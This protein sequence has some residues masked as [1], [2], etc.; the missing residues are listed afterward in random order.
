VSA[1]L[2]PFQ[3]WPPILSLALVSLVTGVG[4]LL[5]FKYTS[6]QRA[7]S[8]TKRRIRAGLLEL[9]L[10]QDSPRLMRR[11]VGE[12][13]LQQ[14]RYLRFA[15]VPGLWAIV[16]L[17]ILLSHLHAYYGYD[18]LQPSTQTMLTVRLA[19]DAASTG[20]PPLSIE[21]PAGLRVETP[22]V[23]TP[24]L[25][26]GAWRIAAER[27]GEYDLRVTASGTDVTKR[28]VVS[29]AVAARAPWRT[30]PDVWDEFLNPAEAPLPARSPIESIG[31]RYPPR[32]ISILG[33]ALPWIVVFLL[34]TS[35]FMF[36]ARS[37][38]N[39]VI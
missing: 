16:P 4:L 28:V 12:L 35:L 2:R 5:L 36:A 33:F 8:E 31:L 11:S 24:A 39:V 10:F 3:S 7:L 6:N 9:R 38:L 15:L 19:P 22:C 34:L 27:P 23:W 18:G 21:A 32:D 20:R 26:E 37:L 29:T 13:L 1:L 25:R 17:G 14:L 30:A